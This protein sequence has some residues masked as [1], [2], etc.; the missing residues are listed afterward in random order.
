MVTKIKTNIS[1]KETSASFAGI[2]VED[3]KNKELQSL[4]KIKKL[5]NDE[6]Y[7]KIIP[8]EFKN[9]LK[10]LYSDL[11]DKKDNKIKFKLSTNIVDE[12]EN[13]PENKKL[14]YLIHRYRYE[15]FPLKKK[16]DSYPPLL[17]IEPTSFCNYRCIF[18]F[19][20]N[21][22]FT[23]RSN[24]HMG[25]MNFDLFKD[26]VDEIQNKIE[27]I[28]LA[29][30]GEPLVSK[31]IVKILKYTEGKFLGAK[32][33]TNASILNEDKAHAILSSGVSTVVFSADAADNELYSKL[34]VNGNLDNVIKNIQKFNKIR[35][36]HYKNR[37]IVTRVSGVK[38]NQVQ[39]FHEMKKV[40]LDLVNQVAF[41]NYTPWEDVYSMSENKIKK[42]CSDL[43][44]RMYIW[45]DGIANPCEV[46]F[47]SNL[48]VGKYPETSINELWTGETFQKLR[49]NH[50]ESKR[51]NIAPCNRCVVI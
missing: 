45:W 19:Q 21:K 8:L 28:N 39:N 4:E 43:W 9:I 11:F 5:Y 29:S 13:I 7:H 18:C 25:H 35:E 51:C 50:S 23:K 26:L 27:F 46:D 31:D 1:N 2:F 48:K 12:F 22:S 6:K 42:P 40:W 10:D 34:R 41:V 14:I 33:N 37:K 49:E 16:I 24:G 30:R 44:R 3:F 20:T 15:I 17:Q 32:L 38:V 36:K 47:K